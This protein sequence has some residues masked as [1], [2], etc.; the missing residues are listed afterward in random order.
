MPLDAVVV[1]VVVD[2]QTGLVIPLL[3]PL[4]RHPALALPRH[5]Q[6]SLTLSDG[7]TVHSV[8]TGDI[9]SK[10]FIPRVNE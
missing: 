1:L 3:Q 8:L 9:K 4:H 10:S 2:D 5:S 7:V 6:T